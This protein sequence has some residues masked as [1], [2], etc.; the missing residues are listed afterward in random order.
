MFMARAVELPFTNNY[1]G[2]VMSVKIVDSVIAQYLPYYEALQDKKVY[3]WCSCGLSKTQPYCDQSHRDTDFKPVRYVAKEEGEEVLFC[4]CKQT[5]TPPFCDGAHNNLKDE[6]GSD[7]PKGVENASVTIVDADEHG[8]AL[9]NGGC[10]VSTVESLTPQY[11]GNLTLRTTV[12]VEVGAVHQSQYHITVGPGESPIISFGESDVLILQTEGA[13]TF[14]ISGQP[15]D[16][17]C[18]AGAYIRSSEALQLINHSDQVAKLFLSVCPQNEQLIQLESMP[19]N[20]DHSQPQRIVKV[21]DRERNTMANRYWQLLVGKDIGCSN[22]TQ[23]IGE[24]PLSKAMPHRH[25]YEESLII[26]SGQGY[27]WTETGKAEVNGGDLI[28]LP[29]KQIHSLECTCAEGLL[30]AGVIY[31]GDNPSINY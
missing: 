11:I 10:F 8:R 28:F 12:S 29:R 19:Q 6:Y 22:A 4:G 23:F 2:V 15:F 5:K 25:L 21:D 17:D 20:F 26:L 14:N 30:V 18:L 31:P 24:I 1:Y 13:L 16:L 7:D 3:L 27:M 9:L